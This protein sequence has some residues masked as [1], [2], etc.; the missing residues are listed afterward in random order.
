MMLNLF[1]NH[2]CNIYFVE[3][4]LYNKSNKSKVKE[5]RVN[6]IKPIGLVKC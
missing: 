1:L 6:E 3:A 4:E 5:K 2:P